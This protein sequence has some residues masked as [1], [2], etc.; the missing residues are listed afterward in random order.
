MV[1]LVIL[2]V[3]GPIDTF[4]HSILLVIC[5]AHTGFE[6]YVPGQIQRIRIGDA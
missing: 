4:D 5:V 1:V 6:P 3:I 2:D